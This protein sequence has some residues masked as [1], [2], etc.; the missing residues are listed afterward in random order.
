MRFSIV[1]TALV[2]MTIAGPVAQVEIE[3]TSDN[4]GT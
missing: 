2:S 3:V 1:A 4:I